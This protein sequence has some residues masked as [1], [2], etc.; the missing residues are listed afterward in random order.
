M[1]WNKN[2]VDIAANPR[3]VV[4]A[5]NRYDAE[6]VKYFTGIQDVPVIPNFCG[7]TGVSYKPT[8]REFLI[9]PGRGIT[10]EIEKELQGVAGRS[11]SKTF[12]KIR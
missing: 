3:N 5:N 10:G 12:K 1:Q 9:G 7:Y 11:S 4:A 8:R 6:Y 2:L